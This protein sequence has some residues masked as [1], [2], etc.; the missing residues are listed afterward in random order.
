MTMQLAAELGPDGVVVNAIAPGSIRSGHVI[1]PADVERVERE[2]AKLAERAA[3]RRLGDP[4]EIATVALF[5]VS[6]AS[7]Y[8]TGQ[9]ITVDGGMQLN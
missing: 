3:L 1:A 6:R 7:S 2:R 5:L 8:L 4:D 9:T